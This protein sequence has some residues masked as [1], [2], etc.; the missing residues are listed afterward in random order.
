MLVLVA[1]VQGARTGQASGHLLFHFFYFFSSHFF[2][3]D[4]VKWKLYTGCTNG[5]LFSQ[6]LKIL[7]GKPHQ[8]QHWHSKC[9][10]VCALKAMQLFNSNAFYQ[11][12][13]TNEDHT[14]RD[15]TL[16]SWPDKFATKAKKS[17]NFTEL[18][19]AHIHTCIHAEMHTLA[20][21]GGGGISL[22]QLQYAFGSNLSYSATLCTYSIFRSRSNPSL[23]SLPLLAMTSSS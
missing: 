9:E 22:L 1:Q 11:M 19:Q 2:S 20:W 7:F 21:E 10:F 3:N 18:E 5:C 12:S 4:E 17:N 16:P 14:D 8:S 6:V 23:F 13:S 15:C